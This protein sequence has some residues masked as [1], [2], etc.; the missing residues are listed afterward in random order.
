MN[1]N[2]I[3][4]QLENPNIYIATFDTRSL[5]TPEKLIELET[6]LESIKWD[7]L[8]TSEVKKLGEEITDY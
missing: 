7:I 3:Y 1:S 5:R 4:Q 6:A 8:G 2:L